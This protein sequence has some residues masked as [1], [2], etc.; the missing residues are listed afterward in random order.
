M[1]ISLFMYLYI[2]RITCLYVFMSTFNSIINPE[3]NPNHKFG[4]SK[5]INKL[6]D[7][8]E[9][10]TNLWLSELRLFEKNNE[11]NDFPKQYFMPFDMR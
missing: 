2:I 8:F 6:I 5:W 3:A 11:N 4:N 10:S 1:F 7:K 9:D